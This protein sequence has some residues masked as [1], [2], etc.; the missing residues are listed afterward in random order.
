MSSNQAKS[1]RADY[2][3]SKNKADAARYNATLDA[4]PPMNDAKIA[5]ALRDLR[6]TNL[7]L[8]ALREKAVNATS[9]R[10]I[11]RI[12]AACVPLEREIR[13]MKLTLGIIAPEVGK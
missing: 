8:Q 10:E 3:R 4:L 12:N 6:E 2:Y 9:A 7:R 1:E 5:R 11:Q 13:G